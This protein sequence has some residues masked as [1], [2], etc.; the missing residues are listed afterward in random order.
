MEDITAIANGLSAWATVILVVVTSFYAWA[1]YQILIA[2]KKLVS[3]MDQQTDAFYRPYITAR[4]EIKSSAK[5]FQ[6]VVENTGKLAAQ[7]LSLELDRDFYSFGKKEE[8]WNIRNLNAFHRVIESFPPGAKLRFDLAQ[9]PSIFG[10]GSD[11]KLT[12]A[13]F[14]IK[15]K[16]SYLGKSVEETIAIDMQPFFWV[17]L[18]PPDP[19]ISELE[20]IRQAVEKL[21]NQRDA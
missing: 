6:L 7:K 12:P 4:A 9:S 19:L 8:M 11:A 16:F 15:A 1:T 5:L 18:D 2:N 21:G 14:N 17:V 13:V 3:A 10:E 20:R